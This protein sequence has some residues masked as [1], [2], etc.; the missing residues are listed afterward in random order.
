MQVDGDSWY[1]W[2][3]VENMLNQLLIVAFILADDRLGM[4]RSHQIIDAVADSIDLV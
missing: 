2:I 4:E 1:N 3:M